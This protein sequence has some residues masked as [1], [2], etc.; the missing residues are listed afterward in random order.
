MSGNVLEWC[1]DWYGSYSSNAQTNPNGPSGGSDRVLRGG[2][3]FN[4]ARLCRVS[5]RLD[6]SPGYGCHDFGLRLVLVP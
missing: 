5:Y 3:W 6:Y 1:Q 2:S 4:R